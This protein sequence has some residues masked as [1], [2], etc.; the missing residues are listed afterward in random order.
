MRGDILRVTPA[1][2]VEMVGQL[3]SDKAIRSSVI[4]MQRQL[5]KKN[6]MEDLVGFVRRH[7]SLEI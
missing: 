7:T 5:N 4:E 6:E 3:L 2:M 1:R